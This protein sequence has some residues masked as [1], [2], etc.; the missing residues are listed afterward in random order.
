MNTPN[1]NHTYAADFYDFIKNKKIENLYDFK[2]YS[3]QFSILS[4]ENKGMPEEILAEFYFQRG[5]YPDI[6]KV[7][8]TSDDKY[9]KG[10]DFIFETSDK[11]IGYIQS[12]GHSDPKVLF[13]DTKGEVNLGTFITETI[14]VDRNRRILFVPY[15]THEP[16]N[17]KNIFSNEF[18]PARLD[19][20]R[21]VSKSQFQ[22]HVLKDP[23]FWSDFIKCLKKSSK[24]FKKL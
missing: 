8:H 11:K 9:R 7:Y 15:L 16:K 21:V 1:I 22:K 3:K 2:K 5:Y 20:I 23:T 24:K 10:I 13:G 14:D 6:L 4:E 12:K 18:K 19:L 17:N